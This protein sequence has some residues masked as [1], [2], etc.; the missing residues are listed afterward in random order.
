MARGVK[1]MI[2]FFAGALGVLLMCGL[3]AAV[4]GSGTKADPY[5]ITDVTELQA[6]DADL[7]ACYVLG[8]D[9]DACDTR[10]WNGGAG[11]EPV[12]SDPNGF[13]GK[14]DGQGHTVTGLYINRPSEDRVGLFAFLTEG[15]EVKNV[16]L[17]DVDITAY[18]GSGSLAG[19]SNGSSIF[20]CW[21][22]GAV[23]GTSS[24][25][26]PIGGLVGGN[27]NGSFMSQCFSLADV[28]AT[29]AGSP[30]NRTGG[31]VGQNNKGSIMLDCYARGNVTAKYK[32][33][34]LVGDNT[35]GSYGGYIKNCY[36]TGHVTGDGGGLVGYN[37]MGGV[38]YD[39]YW[40]K[41]TSG[42]T[43]SHGGAGRTTAEMMQEATFA[44]WDFDEV[45]GIIEGETYPFLLWELS[46]VKLAVA[47]LEGAIG[48]KAAALEALD[49][50]LEQEDEAYAVLEEVLASG[51]YEGLSKRDIDAA[52]RKIESAIRRE[53]RSKRVV[54]GSIEELEDALLSLG[55]EPEPEPNE[56]I[57]EP[58]V[59]EPNVPEPNLPVPGKR[60][61]VF[62]VQR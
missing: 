20:R 14:F 55:W 40:D 27:I 37:W 11:F 49:G 12:G 31:L 56:P 24:I 1:K 38:T 52:Q 25:Q 30:A 19:A 18:G 48:K 17:A 6:V 59:P 33:G 36:S 9:I 21:V 58:N 3:A 4:D 5:I 26:A 23:R 54:A 61:K 13:T 28:Y 53:G 29:S 32:V 43:S 47:R 16:G 57:P 51:D 45:W 34:G 2:V 8:T 22:S 15:A 35:Y 50:A 60:L 44:G 46:G 10:A 7:G 62:R 41:E 39:S 42:K